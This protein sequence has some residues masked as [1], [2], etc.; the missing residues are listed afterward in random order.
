VSDGYDRRIGDRVDMAAI[1]VL[2][3][4]PTPGEKRGWRR[5]RGPEKGLLIDMSVSGLQVRAPAADDLSRGAVVGLAL[6]GVEGRGT[7]RRMA[8]VSGTRFCDYGIELAP[9][10]VALVAWVHD[11]VAGTAPTEADWR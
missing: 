10:A 9:E 6:D 11:R 7:I 3:R 1:P 2:W 4:I 5:P 8:A